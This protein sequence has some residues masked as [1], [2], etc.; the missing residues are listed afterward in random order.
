ML[1]LH[2]AIKILVNGEMCKT[3]ATYAESLLKLYV[4]WGAQLYGAKYV[5]FVHNLIHLANDVRKHGNLDEFSALPF[6]NKLKKMKNLLRKNRK[7][8]QQIV[9]RL[10]EIDRAKSN[11][12]IISGNSSSSIG[13]YKLKGIHYAGQVL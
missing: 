12:K 3:Y 2:V 5:T 10:Q 9:W 8:L 6:E 13:L 1:L 4:T 11:Q 7:P